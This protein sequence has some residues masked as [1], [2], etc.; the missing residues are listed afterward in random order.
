VRLDRE[1]EV[2]VSLAERPCPGTRI[3]EPVATPAGIR[4]VS[5]SFSTT[6]RPPWQTGQ[7]AL[8][9]RPVPPQ[10]RQRRGIRARNVTVPPRTASR[11]GTVRDAAASSSSSARGPASKP[12]SAA[13][14]KSSEKRSL[15]SPDHRNPA[16]AAAGS[17]VRRSRAGRHPSRRDVAGV[18]GR[19]VALTALRVLQ[20]LVRR[21]DLLELPLRGGV[22][23]VHVG[24]VLPREAAVRLLISASWRAVRPRGSRTD[25]S[26]RG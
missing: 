12:D 5:F 19:V 2:E 11:N 25:L 22:P 10:R 21:G 13:A 18:S 6:V 3:F 16:G 7:T 20:Q 14:E 9:A 26:C 1:R 17:A 8:P 15:K 23:G 24:V 4:T